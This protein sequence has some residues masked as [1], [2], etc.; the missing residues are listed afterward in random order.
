M[1][2]LLFYN[3]RIVTICVAFCAVLATFGVMMVVRSM[4][5]KGGV[6]LRRFV[7]LRFRPA[8]LRQTERFEE[9]LASFEEVGELLGRYSP[10]YSAVFNEANWSTFCLYID[11]LHSAYGELCDLLDRGDSREAL[12][13]AEFLAAQ[14]N[15]LSPW[16]YRYISEEW[17]H[18]HNWEHDL[19]GIVCDVIDNLSK[20]VTQARQLGITRGGAADETLAVLESIRTRL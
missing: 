5:S 18:L 14:G 16:K 12:C 6:T 17:E 20:A 13:L 3:S 10:D 11:D 9:T 8:A 1:D 4:I 7:E 2:P 19:Y 15:S